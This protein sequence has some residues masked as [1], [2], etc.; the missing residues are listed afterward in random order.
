MDHIAVST[1]WRRFGPSDN[2]EGPILEKM[3]IQPRLGP[4][5]VSFRRILSLGD[6]Q[7]MQWALELTVVLIAC[8]SLQIGRCQSQARS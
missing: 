4:A 2:S 1:P 7:I 6:S 8:L 3:P 5:R